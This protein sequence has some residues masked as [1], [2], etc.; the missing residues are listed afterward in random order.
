MARFE[1]ILLGCGS[2]TPTLRHMASAQVVDL[3]D[4]LY[5]IDCGEGSQ[6][7]MRRMHIRF[8]RLNHIFISHL[9][10]DH[11]FGLPGLISTLG[12]LGRKGEL[13][14][15]GP[16]ALEDFLRPILSVFCKETPFSVRL[17]LIDPHQHTLVMEDRSVCVY[18][19]PLKHRIPTCGYLFAEKPGEAH[20]IRDMIDFYQIPVK[21]LAGI[22]Q[23][24]DFTTPGGDTIPNSRLTRPADPPKRYAYCSDTAYSPE[25]IPWIEGVDCLYHEATF[26]EDDLPRAKET[27]HS[28]ARQAAEI[29]R[30]AQVKK[31][32]LG[33]YSAR[34]E[35]LAPLQAEAEAVFPGAIIGQEGMALS[36]A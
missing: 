18:S 4:K 19:I 26:M 29:A 28:T 33:H 11:C 16:R 36:L 35:D 1:V 3:R 10:G 27:F 5:M 30:R 15:H 24:A 22:R 23:G 8:N 2:A 31:L 17:N 7:Q 9:H 21:V 32:V 25:I 13:V 20:L 14:I 34:Y 12:M 6:L